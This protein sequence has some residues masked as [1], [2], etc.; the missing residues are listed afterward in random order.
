MFAIIVRLEERNT[1]I[2]LKHNATK[3]NKIQINF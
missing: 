1:Q 3:N 2:Q